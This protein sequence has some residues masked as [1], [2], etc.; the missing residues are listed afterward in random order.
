MERRTKIIVE[1]PA[2][3]PHV[4][5]VRDA[6]QQVLDFF[7]LLSDESE[8]NV[9]WNL[10]AA[11]TNSPLTV[12]GEPIDL[13]TNAGAYNAVQTKVEI[14]ARGLAPVAR[15][16]DFGDE[17][18]RD[19]LD[20]ALNGV[21]ATNFDFGGDEE[22]IVISTPIAKRFFDEIESPVESLHSYLFSR[23]SRQEYGSVE[24][25]V[26]D[27]GTDYEMPAIQ[28]REHKSGRL[29]W[30]RIDPASRGALA[31]TVNAGVAWDHRRVRVR[32]ALNYDDNGKVLRVV[33]GTVSYI[34]YTEKELKDLE[35]DNFTS[36][37]SISEYLDRLRE[38]D[39]GSHYTTLGVF[40]GFRRRFRQGVTAAIGSVRSDC[41][42]WSKPVRNQDLAR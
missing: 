8:K 39:F 20:T 33:N 17:F 15:G 29:I 24:G 19:K 28:L 23:T 38:G 25:R 9:V 6:M 35:D 26:V 5:D 27:I 13:R 34:D 37:Y 32:G 3:H 22:R 30:C 7:A 40:S 42:R 4:L 36:T 10:A 12:E 18:P 14:I 21:G 31:E 16:E 2:E 11:T 1:A 41:R